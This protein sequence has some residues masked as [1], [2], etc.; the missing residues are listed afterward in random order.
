MMLGLFTAFD[1]VI[2]EP[3]PTYEEV[4]SIYPNGRPF[5]VAGGREVEG[6]PPNAAYEAIMVID[7]LDLFSTGFTEEEIRRARS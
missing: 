5:I 7:E 2:T 1:T 6:G 4:Q 3:Y